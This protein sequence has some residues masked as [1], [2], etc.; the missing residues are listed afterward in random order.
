M[1][2]TAPSRIPLHLQLF[3]I[4]LQ[5]IIRSKCRICVPAPCSM[6]LSLLSRHA[7]PVICPCGALQGRKFNHFWL[8]GLRP[9]ASCLFLRQAEKERR[10]AGRPR[11][12]QKKGKL[13]IAEA[14]YF[15]RAKAGLS[16]V[17]QGAGA[18]LGGRR[19]RAGPEAR[20][21]QAQPAQEPPHFTPSFASNHL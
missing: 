19:P 18:V 17:E 2:Q 15:L 21:R 20:P 10:R 12:T 13:P 5:G 1:E 16:A 7:L 3:S 4:S 9:S 8:C 11:I 14:D 6:L